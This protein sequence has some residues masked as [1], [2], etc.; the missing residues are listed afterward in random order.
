MRSKKRKDRKIS[1]RILYVMCFTLM[2]PFLLV[3]TTASKIFSR[4]Y[5][6]DFPSNK[7][8]F[9]ETAAQLNAA[10]PWIYYV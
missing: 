8:V 5:Y 6:S 10:L 3:V 4:L 1:R 9:D 2:Y 7:H